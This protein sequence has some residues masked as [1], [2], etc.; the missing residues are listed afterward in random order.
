M[1]LAALL[2]EMLLCPCL[3]APFEG[4]AKAEVNTTNW[5]TPASSAEIEFQTNLIIC[6]LWATKNL[7]A[8]ITKLPRIK[9][10]IL[11]STRLIYQVVSFKGIVGEEN[12]K[13]PLK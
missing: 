2:T 12:N 6:I 11:F 1:K 7:F 10:G 8:A 3:L 9:K 13:N 5:I 4:A